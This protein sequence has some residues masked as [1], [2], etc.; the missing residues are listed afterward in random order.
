MA[1]ARKHTA[2]STVST[3][4]W[5]TVKGGIAGALAVGAIG[6]VLGGLVVGGAT[7]IFFSGTAALIAGGITAGVTGL[8]ALVGGGTLGAAIGGLLG[9]AKGADKVSHENQ[10]Y[11]DRMDRKSHKREVEV[12]NAGMAGMQQGYQAGFAEGQQY[13]VNQLRAL[14]E[15]QLMAQAVQEKGGHAAKIAK[16]RE[17]QAAT[18]QQIG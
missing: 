6:A 2:G 18:G 1:E 9:L 4:G 17:A 11:R 5:E 10:V 15:Q 7:A 8:A 3:T 12:N 13:M 14:Q 16:Q